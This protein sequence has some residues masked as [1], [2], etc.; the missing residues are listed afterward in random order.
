MNVTKENFKE[1]AEQIE[2]LLP[3]AVFVAFDE[4]MTGI[5]ITGQTDRIEDTPA[6][7]YF[8]MRKVASQYRIIQFGL[9]LFH[10]KERAVDA[11]E[12]SESYEAHVYNFYIFPEEGP[13]NMDASSVGFNR[14]HG[15]DWNKWIREGIP[16]VNRETAQKLRDSLL[17]KEANLSGEK[18]D[19]TPRTRITLTKQSDIETTRNALASLRS[20][21]SDETKKD[22]TEFQVITTNAYLRRFLYE[23]LEADFPSLTV[24]ARPTSARG[25]ST[26]V[27]LRLSEAQKQERAAKLRSD[28]EI[29]LARKVGFTRVFQALA[30]AKKPVVGHAVMYDMLFLLS[31]CEGQLPESYADYKE[32][33]HRLFPLL[34]DTQF[35]AKSEPFKY[36]SLSADDHPAAKR[37]HRFGSMALGAVYRVFL[38]EAVAAKSAGKP[39]VEVCFA[40]GH[41]RYGPNCDAF[42]EAGYDAYVTGYA[43][44]HMAT[45]A[46]CSERASK[47]SGRTTMFRSLFHFNLRGDDELISNGVYVHTRGL[48]GRDNT[49]FKNAFAEIQAPSENGDAPGAVEMEI[50]WIDDDSAF[51][52][53]PEACRDAVAKMIERGAAAGGNVDGLVLTSWNEWLSSQTVADIAEEPPQKRARVSV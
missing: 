4:E 24:E 35:L 12:G 41:D 38:E 23:T 28:R 16:Y 2:A 22:E 32:L 17:P 44:A 11:L 47:L 43:F 46:L 21:L 31:H 18:K 51:A 14:D 34:F 1:A 19:A 48:K 20:W 29:E 15:M 49:D 42:H 3:T 10:K 36:K 37:E 52:V 5:S 13:V 53:L 8:K 50:R 25:E 33:V 40:A 45:E 7:R 26:L 39:T 6:K 9:A 30:N 27:A